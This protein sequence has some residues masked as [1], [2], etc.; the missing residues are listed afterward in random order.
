MHE[1]HPSPSDTFAST[2]SHAPP[3]NMRSILALVSA[4]LL[5]GPALASPMPTQVPPARRQYQPDGGD[6]GPEIRSY[7]SSFISYLKASA[8]TSYFTTETGTACTALMYGGQYCCRSNVVL[9]GQCLGGSVGQSLQGGSFVGR[10]DGEYVYLPQGA[11]NGWV[12]G[13]NWGV[14]VTSIGDETTVNITDN[15]ATQSPSVSSEAGASQTSSSSSSSATATS[16]EATSTTATA[17]NRGTTIAAS[18]TGEGT[19]V[20]SAGGVVAS[21]VV[22]NGGGGSGGSNGAATLKVG[23]GSVVLA[24]VAGAL[25]L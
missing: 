12:E 9:D 21:A 13:S 11:N 18:V 5:A 3:P 2:L 4:L 25:A 15:E 8:T 17:I 7:A 20:V 16:S 19:Q 22:S 1:S 23:L 10:S 6:G 14:Q 24:V